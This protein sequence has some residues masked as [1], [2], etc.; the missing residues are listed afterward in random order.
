MIRLLRLFYLALPPS[1]SH[2]LGVGDV[3]KIR[4]A[5]HLIFY[6]SS[7]LKLYIQVLL[8]C[9]FAVFRSIFIEQTAE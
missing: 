4:C 2:F 7:H 9:N 8:L 3:G 1:P 6:Y 5:V